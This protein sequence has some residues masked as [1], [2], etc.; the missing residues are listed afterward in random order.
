MTGNGPVQAPCDKV[1][2][3]A[4]FPLLA[5]LNHTQSF[6][7]VCCYSMKVDSHSVDCLLSCS[8]FVNVIGYSH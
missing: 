1:M 8:I 7:N 5:L 3:V 6:A 4:A 2:I